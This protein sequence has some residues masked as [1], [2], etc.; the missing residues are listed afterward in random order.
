[1]TQRGN[2]ARAGSWVGS[3]AGRLRRAWRVLPH[4]RRLAAYAACGLFLTLFLPWYQETVIATGRATRLQSLSESLTGW[5]AFSF[6]EAAVLLVAIGVIVLLV[7]RAEGRAFHLPGGDGWVITAAGGWTCVLVI[8]RIFDKQGA[9][10]HGQY[11]TTSGIE[12]GIFV[13]LAVAALLTYAGSR[14]RAAHRPEPPLPGQ[15]GAPDFGFGVRASRPAAAAAAAAAAGE[16]STRRAPTPPRAMAAE[17]PF[18]APGRPPGDSPPP[19]RQP[20]QRRPLGWLTAPPQHAGGA[21]TGAGVAAGADRETAVTADAPPQWDGAPREW[22]ARRAPPAYPSRPPASGSAPASSR[23]G[24]NVPRPVR[25]GEPGD[26][27]A[28]GPAASADDRGASERSDGERSG[29]E[30]SGERRGGERRG[31]EPSHPSDEQLTIP[32]ERDE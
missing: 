10:S 21:G 30:R 14:I 20:E 15:D 25:A 31:G 24:D 12:W 3:L 5:G 6:V 29:G 2:A 27:E 7:Q 23:A 19:A 18:A 8:W 32:L 28:P 1:M 26:S 17:G 22:P 13:A 9:D 11:A 4:E 16:R